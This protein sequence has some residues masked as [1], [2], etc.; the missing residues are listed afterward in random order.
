[1]S[2]RR[3]RL[4]SLLLLGTGV[5]SATY[6]ASI[7]P[8][9]KPYRNPFGFARTYSAGD[10]DTAN[11][12]FRSLGTNGRGCVTC[13]EPSAG[14]SI[15]PPLIRTN[16][17]QTSGQHPLFR[18]VDGANSPLANVSTPEA[19]RV[20]YSLLLN[21]GL[22][23]IGL[24]I[25]PTAE[26]ELSSVD[27]PYRYASARELSLFRR[28]L[29]AT[30]L[31][32]VSDV[33]WDGRET[34]LKPT[35]P[36][37]RTAIN[38]QASLLTQ[39]KNATRLHAQGKVDLTPTQLQQIVSFE[40]GIHTAQAIVSGVGNLDEEGATGGPVALS[41]QS[42]FLGINDAMGHNPRGT[43][44]TA[45]AVTL[46][47]A[48]RTSTNQY[49]AAV[50]RGQEVFNTKRINITGVAGLNDELN[51]PLIV[52]SC[53]TCH[54]APNVGSHS[55]IAPMDIGLTSA[56]R[57]TL[58]LPMYLLRN[59]VTRAV[60]QTTDPGRALITGK[61][62]DIGKFKTPAMRALSARAP[63]FHN[64]SSATLSEV[65]DFYEGRF[66]IG[67]TPKEKEDLVIFMKA[68]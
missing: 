21:K 37:P 48:W 5:G 12:F 66:N 7:I 8:N 57:R 36:D 30:N 62:A 39:A 22:I 50:A 3:I 43:P 31:R 59:K 15:T 34:Q 68:L 4:A 18:P 26:F 58:D 51:Q 19:R 49:R 63:Y 32:F 17:D 47:S 25:P 65:V 40:M 28:P 16:F 38:L 60:R 64:G 61:W 46:F 44:F 9:L 11:P 55:I 54:S 6:A 52:G 10:I 56:A 67:L 2:L 14:F 35:P 13:H 45:R 23:R 33:M 41:Q 53:T 24:P 29:P 27:D 42:F 20:A 1:M